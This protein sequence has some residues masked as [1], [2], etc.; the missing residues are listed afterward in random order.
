MMEKA[1][2][3]RWLWQKKQQK[4]REKRLNAEHEEYLKKQEEKERQRK[5]DAEAK[6][7]NIEQEEIVNAK[8]SGQHSR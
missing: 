3:A 8:T 1:A 5:L 7:K 4:S 6:N 2:V